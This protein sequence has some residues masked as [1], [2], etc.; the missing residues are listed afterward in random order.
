MIKGNKITAHK[1]K[2]T[3][4]T[5]LKCVFQLEIYFEHYIHFFKHLLDWISKTS[6]SE[7]YSLPIVNSN[8]CYCL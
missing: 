4:H 7:E 1:K 5:I 3:T 8:V 2:K 6:S